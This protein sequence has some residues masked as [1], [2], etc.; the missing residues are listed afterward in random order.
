MKIDGTK[1]A[2]IAIFRE[3]VR[4]TS[5]VLTIPL[6]ILYDVDDLEYCSRTE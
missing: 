5:K 2:L 4:N 3:R 6:K 1:V